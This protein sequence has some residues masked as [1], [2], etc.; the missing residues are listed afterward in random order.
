MQSVVDI[1]APYDYN[2]DIL[3]VLKKKSNYSL[4]QEESQT[5][6]V[7]HK[8]LLKKK[9]KPSKISKHVYANYYMKLK[10][11]YF[12]IVYS[13]TQTF[14]PKTLFLSFYFSCFLNKLLVDLKFL[15]FMYLKKNHT[16]VNLKKKIGKKRFKRIK[17]YFFFKKKQTSKFIRK[18]Y[19]K[20]ELLQKIFML[21]QKRVHFYLKNSKKYKKNRLLSMQRR[22]RRK[23]SLARFNKSLSKNLD[24]KVFATLLSNNFCFYKYTNNINSSS[25]LDFTNSW[26]LVHYASLLAYCYTKFYV[27]W[28][29]MNLKNFLNYEETRTLLRVFYA[30]KLLRNFFTEKTRFFNWFI[31]LTYLKNPQS[32]ISLVEEVLVNAHLKK[33]KRLFLTIINILKNWFFFLKK[34]KK[35]KGFS[36]YFKGKLGKKGSVKKTKIFYKLGIISLT[37]KNI[38]LNYKMYSVT[39]LTGVI[40]AAIHIFF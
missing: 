14:P 9:N 13:L 3:N 30:K 12:S 22:P 1:N 24:H 28:N 15:S 34:K 27:N 23:N 37:T 38:R 40:G 21:K 36:L 33:H 39:T 19:Y 29:F 32:F 35:I 26:L 4:E 20:R 7:N 18:R 5:S 10:I 17:K 31:Q 6:W 16:L 25:E 2:K 8:K 11:N